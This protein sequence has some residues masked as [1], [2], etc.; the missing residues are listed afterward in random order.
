MTTQPTSIPLSQQPLEPGGVFDERFDRSMNVAQRLHLLQTRVDYVQKEKK[1]G[2]KYTI[3][4]HDAVTALIRA[5]T[6]KCGLVYYPI[7]DDVK[8]NG[9]NSQVLLHLRVENI[10]NRADFFDVSG[11]GF[12]IDPGDKGPGKA[13][14]YAVK[15]A[16]LKMAGLET[17]DDPDFDQSVRA[18]DAEVELDNRL[19]QLSRE[20]DMDVLKGILVDDPK[21]KD[22]T[23]QVTEEGGVHAQRL[24]ATVTAL[25]RSTG[26]T[27]KELWG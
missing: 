14:S 13:I 26:S 21:I 1:E 19:K 2:M 12:G 6:V 5:H 25:A 18:T 20:S 11:Y 4:S 23:K 17:G 3:V 24:R 9:N 27:L 15:Y 10:D 22:L 7:I 8:V 16:L